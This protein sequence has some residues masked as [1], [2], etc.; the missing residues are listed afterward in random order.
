[1]EQT[2]IDLHEIFRIMRRRLWVL[3]SLPLIAGLVAGVVSLYVLQPVYQASTTMWVVK[4]GAGPI[5]MNDVLLSRNLTKTYAEVARSRAVMLQVVET[6]QLQGLSLDALQKKLTVTSVRDTE[7]LSFAVKDANPQTAAI[8]A[9]AVAEA[10]KA[11]ISKSIK[12]DNVTVVDPA[13]V[14]VAPISPRSKMNVALAIVLGGMAAVGLIFLLEYLDTTIKTPDDVARYL[15]LTV[16]GVIPVI[17][18]VSG[19]VPVSP[20]R[21]SRTKS[22]Q[23]QAVTGK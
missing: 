14:P 18:P 13:Q 20:G 7:I 11:Q 5:S 2:D 17:T 19:A 3:V 8:L 23:S 16:L 6:L 4:E 21:R 15:G 1:M 22:N 10:F 12:V 9:D